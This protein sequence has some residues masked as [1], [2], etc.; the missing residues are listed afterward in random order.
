MFTVPE[1]EMRVIPASEPSLLHMSQP[2]IRVNSLEVSQNSEKVSTPKAK[3]IE[4]RLTR[5]SERSFL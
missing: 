3:A 2:A 1:V 4:T 5:M